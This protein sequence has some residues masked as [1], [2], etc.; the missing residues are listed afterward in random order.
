MLVEFLGDAADDEWVFLL[1]LRVDEIIR[2]MTTQGCVVVLMLWFILVLDFKHVESVGGLLL[3]IVL[4]VCDQVLVLVCSVAVNFGWHIRNFK[5]GL[6]AFKSTNAFLKQFELDDYVLE[7]VFKKHNLAE[8]LQAWVKLLNRPLVS[9]PDDLAL[10]Y[11]L[12]YL[13]E[14]ALVLVH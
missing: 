3:T 6:E 5:L 12:L 11:S 2:A 7:V 13:K 10:L 9:D 14:L 4:A 8:L 1:L